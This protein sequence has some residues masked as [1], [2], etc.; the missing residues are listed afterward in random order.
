M[1]YFLVFLKAN[2]SIQETEHRM[3]W[4]LGQRRSEVGGIDDKPKTQ[5]NKI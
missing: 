4:P 5:D 3:L 1:W 2:Q